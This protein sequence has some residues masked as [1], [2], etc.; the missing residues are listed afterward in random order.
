VYTI[1]IT[2][3]EES[4]PEMKLFQLTPEST[5]H[6]L[7]LVPQYFVL[8]VGEIL[9]AITGLEFSYSQVP[10]ECVNGFRLTNQDNYFWV[11]F[12]KYF[13]RQLGS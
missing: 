1:A 6:I 9:F 7:W 13:W 11:D 3:N 5:V 4:E 2:E 10:T 8:T 12:E